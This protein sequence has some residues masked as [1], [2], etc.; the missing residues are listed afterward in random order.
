[1]KSSENRVSHHGRA[2]TPYSPPSRRLPCRRPVACP[3]ITL[4]Q[5]VVVRAVNS[6]GCSRHF[7]VGIGARTRRWMRGRELGDR[8]ADRDA[9]A[10]V[11]AAWRIDHAAAA[12][13]SRAQQ[14]AIA[15]MSSG[16]SGSVNRCC[17]SAPADSCRDG[18]P[19]ETGM[20]AAAPGHRRARQF[21]GVESW[22]RG[23]NGS[24]GIHRRC[25]QRRSRSGRVRV[26]RG[27]PGAACRPG[28]RSV[29]AAAGGD[30]VQQ[31]QAVFEASVATEHR[32]AEN[33][34]PSWM[35]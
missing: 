14:F 26:P 19:R 35:P 30:L 11:L 15:A 13:E 6:A 5:G 20:A 2:G 7:D 17:W 29:S 27:W 22:S 3:G 31:N 25:H 10:A 16:A 18:A 8:H 24:V 32:F 1:M 12:A 9:L 28:S 33:I 4:V 23:D 21:G 34:W